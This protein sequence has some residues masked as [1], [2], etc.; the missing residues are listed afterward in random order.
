MSVVSDIHKITIAIRH[1]P[2][3]DGAHRQA[4]RH[5]KLYWEVDEDGHINKIPGLE[6]SN[7]AIEIR[8]ASSG[9]THG[10]GGSEFWY[11]FET[12][13]ESWEDEG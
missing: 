1:E 11:Q 10:M 9:S 3:L 5:A 7:C 4:A 8:L 6:R 2:N 12:W 13:I